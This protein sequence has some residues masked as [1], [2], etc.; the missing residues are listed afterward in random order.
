V[1]SRKVRREGD[2]S[3]LKKTRKGREENMGHTN[4]WEATFLDTLV[5]R[6][7]RRGLNDVTGKL[8]GGGD[9]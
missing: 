5:V 7:G 9:K 1:E 2:L 3:Y 6:V 4:R 8:W